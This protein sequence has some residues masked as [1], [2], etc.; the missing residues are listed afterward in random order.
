MNRWAFYFLS[1]LCIYQTAFADCAQC[2]LRGKIDPNNR[3]YSTFLT[4]LNL[5]T[6][7]N[8]Q[9]IVETGTAR[10][11]IKNCAGDG[12]STIIFSEWS[13]NHGASLYSVDINPEALHRAE[14]AIP[15]YNRDCAT[16][17][18][19]DSIE[20]LFNFEKQIDFL[21]LDSYDFN[22]S[23]PIQSQLHYFREIMAAYPWLTPQSIVMIDDCDLPHGGKGKYAIDYLLERGWTILKSSYQVILVHKS[24]L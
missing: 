15:V 23:R 2:Y 8:V 5:L 24:S 21:Y 18:L 9:S 14:Q 1:L 13:T 4:A 7:R 10:H 19:G 11:G 12:C 3:R 22:A 6:E 16:F 17:I 20:F